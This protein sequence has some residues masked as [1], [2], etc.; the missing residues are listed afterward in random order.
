MIK[1]SIL[2]AVLILVG[3]H[4]LLPH[5]SHKFFEFT[6]QQR[7]NYFRAQRYL[8]E[9]PPQSNVIIG[10]S[11]SL[12]LNGD[13]LGP[14]YFKLSLPGNSIFTGLEIIQGAAKRPAVLFIET[15]SIEADADKQFLGDLFSP[16]L[17]PLRSISPIFR[18]EGRPAN[19]ILGITDA[20]LHKGSGLVSHI[21]SRQKNAITA[22][23]VEKLDPAL[24]TQVMRTEA[25]S[26][27]RMLPPD[28]LERHATHLGETV[29][30]LTAEGC[31]CILFEMPIDPSLANLPL[32]AA[33]R[34]AVEKR[35]PGD[36]YHWL[37][38][39]KNHDYETVDGVH[40]TRGA[41]DQLTEV[42]VRQANEICAHL[43]NSARG[44]QASR[45]GKGE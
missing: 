3:Y 7:D 4:F 28:L 14:H 37:A 16:W 18:E 38:F 27:S 15:N 1:K 41:A 21:S 2:S 13:I 6:G 10:S 45:S 24:L 31:V 20:V 30:R 12:T 29:D 9:V 23:P 33:T 11:M 8:Y 35:L 42:L 22:A 43:P 34:R 40:L 36:R 26:Y 25:E 39:D 5:L 44:L 32:P 19:F 17:G